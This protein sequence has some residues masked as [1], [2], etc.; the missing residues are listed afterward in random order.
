M[1]KMEKKETIKNWLYD[2]S[3]KLDIDIDKYI[4]LF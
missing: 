3:K 2:F 1:V 4:H